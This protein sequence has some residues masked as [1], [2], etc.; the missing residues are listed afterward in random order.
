MNSTHEEALKQVSDPVVTSL[1]RLILE[2]QLELEK[3]IMG[4]FPG[5]DFEG[6]RRY[7]EEVIQDMQDRRRMRNGIYEHLFKMGLWTLVL[8][9][10][11]AAWQYLKNTL[12]MP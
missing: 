5:G 10:A 4:A 11:A 6:H 1:L 8:G 7:H 3:M 12:K 2:R 9:G